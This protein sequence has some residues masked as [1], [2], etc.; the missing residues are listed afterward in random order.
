MGRDGQ[1]SDGGVRVPVQVPVPPLGG[2]EAGRLFHRLLQLFLRD[3]KEAGQ[4]VG[5]H[6]YL[7]GGVVQLHE[8]ARAQGGDAGSE[9][10]R[11]ACCGTPYPCRTVL[12]VAVSAGLPIPWDS[13]AAVVPA[14]R[15][16]GLEPRPGGEVT[17]EQVR[18]TRGWDARRTAHGAWEIGIA[19]D[20]G[21]VETLAVADDAAMARYLAVAAVALGSPYPY[22]WAED[23]AEAA[24]V[25]PAAH[26]QVAEWRERVR[27]PF[28]DVHRQYGADGADE[29]EAN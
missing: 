15:D 11:C 5:R 28:L 27:L 4:P 10:P 7:L 16:A 26:A 24:A 21:E 23:E 2:Y 20:R 18:W 17:A 19:L 14:L 9:Q 22:G 12:G 6:Q 29:G 13:P 8:P 3:S 1:G 25:R